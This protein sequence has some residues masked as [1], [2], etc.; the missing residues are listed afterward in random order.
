VED[1]VD[2]LVAAMGVSCS[3]D[4]GDVSRLLDNAD[5]AL[6]AGWAGAVGAGID[7]GD[8]VADGAEAQAGLE[9]MHGFSQRRRIVVGGAQDVKA[10]RS[11]LL[12]PTPGSFFN[13]SMSRAI[14]SA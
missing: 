10:K 13:S 12:A 1:V 9:V 6:I 4:R 14:G 5:Q 7:V 3:L 8:V 2:A 11:A